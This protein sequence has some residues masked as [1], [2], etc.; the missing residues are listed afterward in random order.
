MH[1]TASIVRQFL[2]SPLFEN[3]GPPLEKFTPSGLRAAAHD[4]PTHIGTDRRAFAS[5]IGPS[6]AAPAI[7][8]CAD[9]GEVAS[10]GAI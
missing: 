1:G 9:S 6:S 7:S 4:V 10:V 2:V 8:A 5:G 3:G